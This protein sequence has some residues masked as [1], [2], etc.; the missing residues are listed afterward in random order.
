MLERFGKHHN[1]ADPT[2]KLVVAVLIV[3]TG[4]ATDYSCRHFDCCV[5]SSQP[6][7]HEGNHARTACYVAQSV[8]MMP[9]QT[10]NVNPQM[11]SHFY[12]HHHHPG[13][14]LHHRHLRLHPLQHLHL[15]QLHLPSLYM[16][17][18]IL[19]SHAH[20]LRDAVRAILC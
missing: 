2:G 16:T 18:L 14:H 15:L 1:V 6:L 11:M 8:L 3:K 7:E 20:V 19:N 9:S 4:E 13:L 10:Q 5:V 12:P 17:G